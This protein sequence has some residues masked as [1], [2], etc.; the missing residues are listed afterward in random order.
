[1]DRSF[2]G[3]LTAEQY[4]GA[5]ETEFGPVDTPAILTRYQ[6][7]DYASPKLALSQIACDVEAVCEARRVARLVERTGTPVYLYSFEREVGAVAGDQVIH[8][9]DRNFV[10]GI[11]YGPPSNYALDADDLMLFDVISKYWTRFAWNGN[12]NIDDETAV[13][14]PA[15]KHPNGRGRGANKYLV[16]DWPLRQGKR[17]REAQCD[18]WEPYFLRSIVDGSVPAGHP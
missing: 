16:L 17:L 12:P 6:L 4:A 5:V 1:V 18:F 10:F 14:W 7:A 13:H 8:G 15:F 2:P 9:L 3:G 11:N